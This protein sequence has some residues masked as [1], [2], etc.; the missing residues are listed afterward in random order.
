M[1]RLWLVAS[2]L[3]YSAGAFVASEQAAEGRMMDARRLRSASARRNDVDSMAMDDSSCLR[4]EIKQ[5]EAHGSEEE[6]LYYC[7]TDNGRGHR[8]TFGLWLPD[9][10]LTAH[11]SLFDSGA[12]F[13]VPFEYVSSK[14]IVIPEDHR[15]QV[16]RDMQQTNYAPVKG[17]MRV[18]AVRV[19]SITGEE[20]EESLEEIE[21]GIFGTTT[22]VSL[23]PIASVTNQYRLASHGALD[24]QPASGPGIINGVTEIT[25]NR[26]VVGSGVQADLSSAVLDATRDV[27]GSL[28]E[29]ADRFIFCLPNGSLLEGRDSW[30]AF[31][32]LYEPVSICFAYAPVVKLVL[33]ESF[34]HL[35]ASHRSTVQLLPAVA[36][37][38]VECRHARVGTQLWLSTL[39]H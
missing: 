39:G 1:N 20:P 10:F 14:E 30:T 24:L 4:C 11:E 8:E 19:R 31:T 23:L 28:D 33:Y 21:A 29:V 2:S 36:M 17:T 3:L 15:V 13:C 16:I 25:V 18:L 6:G 27:V 34:S 38:Q 32:F 7:I 35:S 37:Q 12:S 26:Q 9:S 5:L 22:D